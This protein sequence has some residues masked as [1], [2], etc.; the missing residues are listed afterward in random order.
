M[1][2]FPTDAAEARE[3]AYDLLLELEQST[4]RCR[5]ALRDALALGSDPRVAR[6][7]A[8]E[9]FSHAINLRVTLELLSA[10]QALPKREP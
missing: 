8:A 4:D 1:S 3:A 5:Y 6:E 9:L 2:D 7:Y 10:Y